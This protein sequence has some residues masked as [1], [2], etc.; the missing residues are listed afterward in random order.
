MSN[1][2]RRTFVGF[3]ALATAGVFVE[4]ALSTACAPSTTAVGSSGAI[5]QTT[6]GQVRG[7]VQDKVHTFK[8]MPYGATT[9]DAG[10]FMPPAKPQ[11]WNNV[12]DAFALGPRAP[13]IF[14]GEPAEV[15]ATDPREAL[16]EDCL[17][18]NVWT[19]S[20]SDGRRR[21][22]MVWLH[23]GG[24]TSGSGSYSMY[25]GKE[26]ARKHDVVAIS[27]NHRLNVFG[28]LYL[29]EVGG[30]KYAN[31]SNVGM[32]DI[33]AALEWV[34]DNI[35]AF[36]GDPGNV[37]IFG[38]SGGAGKVS[39]LMAMPSAKGLFHRAV[40]QSGSNVRG[41]TRSDANKTA[42]MVLSKLGLT[43]N[44]VDDLQTMPMDRLLSVMRGPGP[45]APGA[46]TLGPVVDGRTLPSSPFEPSAPALSNDIPLLTGTT[47]TEVTFFSN[48]QLDPIDDATFRMRVKELLTVNDAKAD[49][50]IAVYRKNRPTSNNIDLFLRMSTDAGFFRQGVDTQ[51]IRKA[52]AGKTPVY[53]YR[54]DWYSPVREG[55]LKAYHTLEIPFVFDN[56]DG[57][58]T[59]TGVGK[60]RYALADRMSAAWVA[61][62]RTGNPQ[63]PGLPDWP[64]FN[65]AQR[66]T[67]VF[68]NDC[69]LVNDP[70]G[71][72]RASLMAARDTA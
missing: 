3:G 71:E 52:A 57:S 21:P 14:G 22:V 30:A 45:G 25:D 28:F 27:I 53:V 24:Y 47:A 55:K 58:P 72:E 49:K 48:T 41:I 4:S 12:R 37:T 59:M 11:P 36:G 64:P 34:R 10:R 66:P 38:Q 61:F 51:A 17:C 7:L 65:A 16:G 32:L 67:M 43:T 56:V 50:V 2:D 29:A 13:Q 42:E 19:P 31:A 39:T 68:D 23:G 40:A 15:A 9:A 70:G 18:L 5:V 33:V 6:A 35:A 44:Q 8:G 26:L 63:H 1:I 46:L 62:A 54:F 60:E 69:K 20:P